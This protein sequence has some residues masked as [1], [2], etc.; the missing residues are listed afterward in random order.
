MGA[1][2]FLGYIIVSACNHTTNTFNFNNLKNQSQIVSP[3]KIH[4]F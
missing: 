2:L 1:F 3:I 4:E